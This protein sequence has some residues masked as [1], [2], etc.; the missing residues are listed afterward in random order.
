VLPRVHQVYKTRWLAEATGMKVEPKSGA[1]PLSSVY[2][3]D[4]LLLSYIGVMVVPSG[5]APDHG[6]SPA[7][8]GV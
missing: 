8:Y 3:T 5:A 6:A 4:A 7:H 2:E 1:T